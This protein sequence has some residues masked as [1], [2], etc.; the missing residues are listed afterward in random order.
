MMQRSS[1]HL[2]LRIYLEANKLDWK[3]IGIGLTCILLITGG[4]WTFMISTYEED[5]GTS[6]IV[7]KQLH[8]GVGVSHRDRWMDG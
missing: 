3:V 5:L 2:Y 8:F 6:N 1:L 4:I 7:V